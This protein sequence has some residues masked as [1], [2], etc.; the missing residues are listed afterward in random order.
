MPTN[1]FVVLFCRPEMGGSILPWRNKELLKSSQMQPA[2]SH[3]TARRGPWAT[4]ESLAGTNAQ[5]YWIPEE[6][7]IPFH[8]A[9][10]HPSDV[11]EEDV[12]LVDAA[13][14]SQLSFRD[15]F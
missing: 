10:L 13:L 9:A 8:K 2:A 3:F 12:W 14:V 4:P 6:P 11:R 15:K 7:R 5:V 1:L